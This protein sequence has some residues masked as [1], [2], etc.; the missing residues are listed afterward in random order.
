MGPRTQPATWTRAWHA[1]GRIQKDIVLVTRCSD[2]FYLT[3]YESKRHV[4]IQRLLVTLLRAQ[5]KTLLHESVLK[6]QV[7]KTN[8]LA[9]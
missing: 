9:E 5:V 1:A 6:A 7:D 3:Q 8:A 4:V 2:Q